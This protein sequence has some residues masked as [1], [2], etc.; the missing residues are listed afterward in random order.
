MGEV[1]AAGVD[2]LFAFLT[3][4]LLADGERSAA[5]TWAPGTVRYQFRRDGLAFDRGTLIGEAAGSAL[6]DLR[7][8][9]ADWAQ[10]GE[11][12]L[13]QAAPGEADAKLRDVLA[14]LPVRA[15][16]GGDPTASGAGRVLVL[17]LLAD[18]SDELSGEIRDAL[19]VAGSRVL[20]AYAHRAGVPAPGAQLLDG[21]ACAT[22]ASLTMA[23]GTGGHEDRVVET[24]VVLVRAALGATTRQGQGAVRSEASESAENAV[25]RIERRL[26][27]VSDASA[28]TLAL[29]EQLAVLAPTG[30][31]VFAR[32]RRT[33]EGV[34]DTPDLRDSVAGERI[35]CAAAETI[36]MADANRSLADEAASVAL[37]VNPLRADRTCLNAGIRTAWLLIRLER[38]DEARDQLARVSGLAEGS[39]L[40]S[41]RA[42]AAG[43]SAYLVSITGPLDDVAVGVQRIAPGPSTDPVLR[44]AQA[45][46]AAATGRVA[47]LRADLDVAGL[48]LE[49]PNHA[50]YPASL[51]TSLRDLQGAWL[52]LARGQPTSALTALIA[53]RE[54]LSRVRADN[55]AAWG[56]LEP[57]V[58]AL[59]ALGREAEARATIASASAAARGWGTPLVLAELA[60]AHSLVA[61]N[62][63]ARREALHH[64]CELLDMSRAHVEL[65]R[66]Q[67]ALALLDDPGDGARVSQSGL[68]NDSVLVASQLTRHAPTP[69]T[70]RARQVAELVATGKRN[71]QI[72]TTL[73]LAESTVGRHVSAAMRVTGTQNRAELAAH[74]TRAAR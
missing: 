15:I 60:R 45:V 48:A 10:A 51:G 5:R 52:A 24:A 13:E 23:R 18:A 25:L 64:A 56:W 57:T 22:I 8:E 65:E 30:D 43:F 27:H 19:V 67:N 49:D 71:A 33:L 37:L 14:A 2:E 66:T 58:A 55:P 50:I 69:M 29:I 16:L 42:L 72:A 46:G 61:S 40:V 9:L 7:A 36:S 21:L 47:L 63:G 53:L 70:P 34:L 12:A 26:E 35:W 11:S 17:A 62:P 39:E 4:A 54:R 74:V 3:P 59:T 44:L 31:W 41:L 6:A 68:A 20:D 73:G 32:V 38:F 28:E 1:A